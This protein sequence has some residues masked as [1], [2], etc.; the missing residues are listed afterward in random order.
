VADE[1]RGRLSRLFLRRAAAQLVRRFLRIEQRIELG[2][3]RQQFRSLLLN[4]VTDEG[5]E[6][7]QGFGDLAVLSAGQFRVG[8]QRTRLVS[9]GFRLAEVALIECQ[10][11]AVGR[12]AR[13]E[14]ARKPLR[15]GNP[16]F[17]LGLAIGTDLFPI[18]QGEVSAK[19]SD[20]VSHGGSDRQPSGELEPPHEGS[21]AF[22]DVLF[23]TF[24]ARPL[25]PLRGGIAGSWCGLR[26]LGI[27]HA[28]NLLRARPGSR[29]KTRTPELTL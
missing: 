18:L 29:D 9:E 12:S 27:R 16:C 10:Q 22:A 19:S 11:G 1:L 26:L 6:A 3:Q 7:G 20:A 17:Q 23:E 25:L 13:L 5:A 21:S 8:D 24:D 2:D 15:V 14:R 4:V 28:T